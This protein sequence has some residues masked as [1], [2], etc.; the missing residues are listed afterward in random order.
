VRVH[1][2]LAEGPL[3]VRARPSWEDPH[4]N[5]HDG[6]EVE[7]PSDTFLV[8]GPY[9]D[10]VPLYVSPAVDWSQVSQVVI[11]VRYEDGDYLLDKTLTFNAHDAAGQ[12]L[13]LPLLDA[14]K[15]TY[16]W[17]QTVFRLDGTSTQSD[18]A[19]ADASVLAPAWQKPT[20]ADVRIVWVGAA[21]DAFGLRVDVWA[22]TPSGDEQQVSAFLRTG[23][24]GEKVVTL[25]LDGEGKLSYRYQAAK[26]S[27]A[28]ETPVRSATEQSAPLLVVQTS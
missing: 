10:L 6:D 23:V 1:A 17:R 27:A 19:S 12:R 16:S 24:D 5:I 20:T 26:L 7:V 25:P 28:G 2:G 8:L 9:A 21:G 14:A 11:E 22:E 4:G 15:R 18:F 3:R 13:D